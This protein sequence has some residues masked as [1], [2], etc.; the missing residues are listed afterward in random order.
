VRHTPLSPDTKEEGTVKLSFGLL[1]T[2]T[3]PPLTG[4]EVNETVS[5]PK[6]DEEIR[7]RFLDAYGARRKER[8]GT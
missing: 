5:G 7:R 4:E 2:H 1:P 3:P 8:A 6:R